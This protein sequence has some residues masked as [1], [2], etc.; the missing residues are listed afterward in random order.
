MHGAFLGHE[1][2]VSRDGRKV[3]R[4]LNSGSGS[5]DLREEWNSWDDSKETLDPEVAPRGINVGSAL[6]LFR[7]SWGAGFRLLPTR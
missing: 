2:C 6:L 7:A 5:S 3:G 1:W 4:K